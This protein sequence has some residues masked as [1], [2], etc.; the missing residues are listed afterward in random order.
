MV[1]PVALL[2]M[3][4]PGVALFFGPKIGED[5]K[6]DLRRKL[7]GFSVQMR[8]GTKQSEK[9]KVFTANRWSYTFT[10][11]YGVTPKWRRSGRLPQERH[12]V[13]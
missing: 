8:I 2:R 12:W 5:Q 9:R 7:S 6:K 13:W 1:W 11:Y 3:I 4:V 10:S